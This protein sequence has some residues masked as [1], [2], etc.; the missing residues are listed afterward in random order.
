MLI[1]AGIDSENYHRTLDIIAKQ[2]VD[3][4]KG[5]ISQTEYERAVKYLTASLM[6]SNDS[7]HS[8]LFINQ[9]QLIDFHIEWE[10]S[11]RRNKEYEYIYL[12]IY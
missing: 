3:I 2:I 1:S 11:K 6:A 8:K 5:E 7:P 10:M 12:L 4:R 9:E